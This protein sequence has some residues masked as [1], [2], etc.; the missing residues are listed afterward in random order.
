MTI[1]AYFQEKAIQLL[2][3]ESF[4]GNPNE[5]TC[6]DMMAHVPRLYD[7]RDISKEI[8]CLQELFKA[9]LLADS[10]SLTGY[11]LSRTSRNIMTDSL[12]TAFVHDACYSEEGGKYVSEQYDAVFTAT[13]KAWLQF[14]IEQEA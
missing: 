10:M 2:E 3:D 5:Y 12:C 4:L 11:E 14:I 1:L 6:H 7:S 9:K 8:E 13:R